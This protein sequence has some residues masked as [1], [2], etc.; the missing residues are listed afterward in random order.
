MCNGEDLCPDLDGEEISNRV[1]VPRRSKVLLLFWHESIA[2]RLL[3]PQDTPTFHSSRATD[4]TCEDSVMEPSFHD[5]RLPADNGPQ[6][7]F[8]RGC[9][10]ERR[11]QG[12]AG[13]GF[14]THGHDHPHIR[15]MIVI[16]RDIITRINAHYHQTTNGVSRAQLLSFQTAFEQGYNKL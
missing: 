15:R 3:Q 4:H 12:H 7:P 14:C 13:R 9:N 11:M 6:P 16:E 1:E 8:V 5:C 10:Q 2:A